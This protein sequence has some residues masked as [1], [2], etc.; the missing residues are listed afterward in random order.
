[1]VSGCGR[2]APRPEHGRER[3]M[4]ILLASVAIVMLAR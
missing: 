2:T 1:M 4:D 3:V